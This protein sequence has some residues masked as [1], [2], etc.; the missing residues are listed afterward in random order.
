M[1][2]LSDIIEEKKVKVLVALDRAR[3]PAPLGYIRVSSGVE[4]PYEL[5]E[6]LEKDGLVRRALPS[7][8]SPAGEPRFELAPRAR[9]TL[10][11]LIGDRLN[12]L[13]IQLIQKRSKPAPLLPDQ[14]E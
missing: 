2:S 14:P 12:Q 10:Q 5:L 7:N 8:W 3:G 13:I 11:K 6:E 1:K 9:K 4:E